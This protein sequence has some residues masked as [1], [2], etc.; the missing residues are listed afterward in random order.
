VKSIISDVPSKLL[1]PDTNG[2]SVSDTSS[3]SPATPS[4]EAV[5]PA[6]LASGT[7][8]LAVVQSLPCRVEELRLIT[9]P[10]RLEIMAVFPSL[11]K[12]VF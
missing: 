1:H 5:N 3:C 4:S 6:L 2:K 8:S 12:A 10:L 9:F 7:L 11:L